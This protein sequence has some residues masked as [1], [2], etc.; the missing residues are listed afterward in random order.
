MNFRTYA[1]KRETNRETLGV[2]RVSR[3]RMDKDLEPR[4]VPWSVV[5]LEQSAV[6]KEEVRSERRMI[7]CLEILIPDFQLPIP[8]Q[9]DLIRSSGREMA[10]ADPIAKHVNLT[11]TGSLFATLI[12]RI[13]AAPE[14]IQTRINTHM[15]QTHQVE[16]RSVGRQ[17]LLIDFQRS[18]NE[19]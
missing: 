6:H 18:A 12:S 17:N 7:L 15:S 16:H 10:G 14:I 5:V 19:R 3:L 13:M 2:K 9:P 11:R 8:M 1:T 4:S